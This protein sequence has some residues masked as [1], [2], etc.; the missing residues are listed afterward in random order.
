M[1]RPTLFARIAGFVRFARFHAN[2]GL[3]MR[4]SAPYLINERVGQLSFDPLELTSGV[5]LPGWWA[6]GVANGP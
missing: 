4:A 5:L 6:A 2:G 1:L 3:G